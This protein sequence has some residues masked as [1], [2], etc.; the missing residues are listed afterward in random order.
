MGPAVTLNGEP[1]VQELT[2]LVLHAA[3]G[4]YDQPLRLLV[5]ARPFIAWSEPTT[6]CSDHPAD[7]RDVKVDLIEKIRILLHLLGENCIF[8]K[9]RLDVIR[10][11]G[12][13]QR[14]FGRYS[15]RTFC[16]N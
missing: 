10:I 16:G 2:Q 11:V 6:A 14:N 3:L 4:N 8:L 1:N 9:Q 13:V 15:V 7:V 12:R 5:L